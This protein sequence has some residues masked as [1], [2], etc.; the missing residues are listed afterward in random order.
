MPGYGI[1]DDERGLLP[2]PWAEEQLTTAQRYWIATVAPDG[3]PHSMPVWAVWH[4]GSLWFSTG[5]RTRKARNLAAEPRCVIHTD[6][7]DPVIVH[8]TAELEH[9]PAAALL[10]A[11]IA[12]YGQAPP[13]PAENPIIRVRPVWAFGIVESEFATSPTRWDF[14]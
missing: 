12:K 5:G 1:A 14:T 7:E 4:D 6:G 11:Y 9:E 3:A 13:D 8:G 10:E 2:W